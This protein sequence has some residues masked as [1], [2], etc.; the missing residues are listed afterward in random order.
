MFQFSCRF[1]FLL[2]TIRLSNRTPKTTRILT[3]YQAN[4]P[5]LT[6]YRS[7]T[8]CVIEI[9][10]KFKHLSQSVIDIIASTDARHISRSSDARHWSL[11]SSHSSVAA[12]ILKWGINNVRPSVCLSVCSLHYGQLTLIACLAYVT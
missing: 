3:L 10:C 1:A 12:L 2:Q 6:R 7:S 5:T 4:A 11:V 9:E 8:F